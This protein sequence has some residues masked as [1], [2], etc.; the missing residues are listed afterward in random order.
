MA[1]YTPKGREIEPLEGS[2]DAVDTAAQVL[3]GEAE[4]MEGGGKLITLFAEGEVTG[5]AGNAVQRIGADC[6]ENGQVLTEAATRYRAMVSTMRTYSKALRE[7]Q[8]VISTAIDEL[9]ELE[10][11]ADAAAETWD[12]L[13]TEVEGMEP[14]DPQREDKEQ[15]RDTAAAVYDQLYADWIEKQRSFDPL[16][17][18]FE[19]DYDAAVTGLQDAIDLPGGDTT[20]EKVAKFFGGLGSKADALAMLADLGALAPPLT[21]PLLAAGRVLGGVALGGKLAE[22][23]F[24]LA[25]GNFTMKNVWDLG[26]TAV[27][28]VPFAKV[29]GKPIYKHVVKN[30][31]ARRAA[32]EVPDWIQTPLG[33]ILTKP[34]EWATDKVGRPIARWAWKEHGLDVR[35]DPTDDWR[36]AIDG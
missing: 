20:G 35:P 15:E 24:D 28:M 3:E 4:L 23:F 12:E 27:G 17:D 13:K 14:D 19:I 11:E 21:A 32:S 25:T 6:G 10:R 30:V 5:L 7:H 34:V 26:T 36:R 22:T 8:K 31:G 9:R 1:K 18:A 33:R 29:V 2:P 16:F